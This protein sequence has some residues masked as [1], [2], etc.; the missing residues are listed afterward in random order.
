[1]ATYTYNLAPQPNW[2]E[3]QTFVI[4]TSPDTFTFAANTVTDTIS[5]NENPNYF[6]GLAVTVS[7]TLTLPSPL[8]TNVTYYIIFVS[9]NTYKLAT[10]Y[11]N[12]LSNTAIDITTAGTGTL[13]ITVAGQVYLKPLANGKIYT[14]SSLNHAENKATYTD[15]TGN[16]AN[17]NPII[18]DNKGQATIYWAVNQNDNTDNYYIE[19][20]DANDVLIYSRDNFNAPEVGA[21]SPSSVE[22]FTNFVRNNCFHDWQLYDWNNIDVLCTTSKMPA[23]G[24][25]ET[26][27]EWY[28]TKNNNNATE[29]VSRQT[30][31]AGQPDVPNNPVYFLQANCTSAGAGGETFKYLYQTYESFQTFSGEDITLSFYAKAATNGTIL[32][33]NALQNFG[34]SGSADVNISG[35]SFSLSTSFQLFTVTFNVPSVSGKTPGTTPGYFAIKFNF[36]INSAFVISLADM[37]LV[38]GATAQSFIQTTVEEQ[39]QTLTVTGETGDIKI[40]PDIANLPRTWMQLQDGTIGNVTSTASLRANEDTKSLFLFLWT[41]YSDYICPSYTS[42]GVRTTRSGSALNDFNAG[43]RLAFFF[44]GSRTIA[45]IGTPT[46]NFIFTVDTGADTVIL[47]NTPAE[48]AYSF[49]TG[50]IVQVSTT[51]ALPTGLLAATNY[52]L[53]PFTATTYK[54]AATLDD[55]LAGTPVIGITGS[56]SGIQTITLFDGA[57]RSAG[58]AT[59]EA[60]HTQ[61]ATEVG[62][63][64]H[65]GALNAE[66]GS[67]AEYNNVG[68]EHLNSNRDTSNNTPASTPFN[69][70]QSTLWLP[71]IIKL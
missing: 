65:P 33:V 56:G 51:G 32:N 57:A 37:Q 59:G 49:Y 62:Q 27:T 66:Q 48:A 53:I 64:L 41:T 36:P 38:K 30:F 5:M 61:I 60:T 70:I 47:T 16:T 29:T 20:R 39:N 63:H 43:N 19:V 26:A 24:F 9:T 50:K 46:I 15:W 17:T 45:N 2:Q 34:T 69:L 4:S 21:N 58:E 68:S 12:A 67:G 55:A 44:N 42:A 25:V 14:H 13:S 31:S 3:W 1:M 35:A 10:S 18:L 40:H 6:T 22:G 23:A 52:Y 7:S 71:F 11:A 28:F 8:N 54:L